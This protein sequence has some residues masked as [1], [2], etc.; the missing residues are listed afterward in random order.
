LASRF[1][2]ALSKIID[3]DNTQ[4]GDQEDSDLTELF[5][6]VEELNGH[7]D[8]TVKLN[9]Q[10]KICNIFSKNKNSLLQKKI[11]SNLL[12]PK[13]LEILEFNKKEL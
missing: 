11:E 6:L 2:L 12:D 9:N 10:S 3:K 8:L 13:I 1:T 7:Q 5:D 4:V